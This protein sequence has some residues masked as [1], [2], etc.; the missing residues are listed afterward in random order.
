MSAGTAPRA[1]SVSEINGKFGEY[2]VA[3]LVARQGIAVTHAP[4]EGF[5]LFAVDHSGV[6]F[7]PRNKLIG[8]SVKTRLI[9]GNYF[10][11]GTV[12]VD[13]DKLKKAGQIW[14]AECWVGVVLGSIGRTLE[15]FVLPLSE[16]QRFRGRA[17]RADVVSFSALRLDKSGAVRKLLSEQDLYTEGAD[18][19]KSKN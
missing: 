5:D 2:L 16:C 11:D 15:A 19:A 7:S 18:D 14:Q 9:K 12:G 10:I 3:A 17:T 6:V 1:I 4:T 13:A 8:I